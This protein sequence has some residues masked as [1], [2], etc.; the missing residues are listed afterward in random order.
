[1]IHKVPRELQSMSSRMVTA[2]IYHPSGLF[3]S[4][5]AIPLYIALYEFLS[6]DLHN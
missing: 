2:Q 3:P 1:M 4:V 6:M 5:S